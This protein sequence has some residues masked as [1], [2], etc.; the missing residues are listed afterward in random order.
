[1]RPSRIKITIERV[2]TPMEVFGHEINQA[3]DGA[4]IPPC[5]FFEKG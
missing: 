4:A 5:P 1:M 3:S 2:F